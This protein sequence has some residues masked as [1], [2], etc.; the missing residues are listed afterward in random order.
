MT[1]SRLQ[2]SAIVVCVAVALFGVIGYFAIPAIARWA[3]EDIG[4]REI[5]RAVRVKSIS[6]NPYTMRLTVN[7]LSVAG[8][9]G[10]PPL[11]TVQQAIVNASS[12]SVLRLAP[13]IDAI[14]ITG[15]EANIVRLEAQRFN[16][17][18]IIERL[19]AKPKTD[20]EPARF[21]LH[22]IELANGNVR[23][24]DRI[25][26]RSTP[27]QTLRLAF[28]SSPICRSMLRSRCCRRFQ[29]ASTA[30]YSS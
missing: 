18:D 21:A 4:S 17:D 23:F 14:S 12:S 13:V 11:L 3:I 24:D 19:R 28:H 5:G 9:P 26:G 25:G 10:E 2:I 20:G 1:L 22:N 15:V 6:A 30:P 27:S 29:L 16:F 8:L 7:D